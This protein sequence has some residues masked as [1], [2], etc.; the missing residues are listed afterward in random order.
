MAHTKSKFGTKLSGTSYNQGDL[1]MKGYKIEGPL[2]GIN[3]PM[4]PEF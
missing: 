4:S 2:Y 1:K 3:Y